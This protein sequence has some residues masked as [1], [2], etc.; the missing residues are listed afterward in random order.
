[1]D[2]LKAAGAQWTLEAFISA[3]LRVVARDPETLLA[4][5]ANDLP[6]RHEGRPR[7]DGQPPRRKGADSEA[8]NTPPVEP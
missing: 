6:N 3:C 8:G 1:M 2:A 4:L 5:L 7:K